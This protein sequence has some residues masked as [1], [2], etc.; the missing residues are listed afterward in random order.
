MI[1]IKNKIESQQAKN[2][3]KGILNFRTEEMQFYAFWFK[4]TPE[5]KNNIEK[6]NIFCGGDENFRTMSF[7]TLN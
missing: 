3:L 4:F 5:I 2:Y 7:L 1:N 6:F